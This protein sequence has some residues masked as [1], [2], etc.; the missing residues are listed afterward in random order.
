MAGGWDGVVV[1]RDKENEK[2]RSKFTNSYTSSVCVWVWVYLCLCNSANKTKPQLSLHFLSLWLMYRL[3]VVS[4]KVVAVFIQW[5]PSLRYSASLA[6]A[7]D[8]VHSNRLQHHSPCLNCP[9]TWWEVAAGDPCPNLASIGATS[10]L[11]LHSFLLPR[12]LRL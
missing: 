5:A 4:P 2:R 6:L 8:R 9:P 7:L 3:W 10:V 1:R 12:L 11:P